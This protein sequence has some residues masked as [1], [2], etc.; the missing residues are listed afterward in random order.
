MAGGSPEHGEGTGNDSD[1]STGSSRH[2]F[3]DDDK[4]NLLPIEERR[5]LRRQRHKEQQRDRSRSR[6]RER[7]R[8]RRDREKRRRSRTRSRSRERRRERDMSEKEVCLRFAE[9]GHC[10]EVI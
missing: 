6:S 1:D 10:P 3:L 4:I 8:R 5:A 2:S 9:H 7:D